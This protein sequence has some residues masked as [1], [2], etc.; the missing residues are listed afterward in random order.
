MKLLSLATILSLLAIAI[1]LVDASWKITMDY[2]GIC[3]WDRFW[4]FRRA[5]RR[6]SR[7][8][9]GDMSDRTVVPNDLTKTA[10][11]DY[12]S[13]ID[14]LYICASKQRVDGRGGFLAAAGATLARSDEQWQP[15]AGVMIFDRDDIWS[16]RWQRKYSNFIVSMVSCCLSVRSC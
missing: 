14:D 4:F 12:P 7:A 5:A 11:G 6:W 1:P 13:T 8:I 16:M 10:C 2:S 15:Y 9:V 3:F